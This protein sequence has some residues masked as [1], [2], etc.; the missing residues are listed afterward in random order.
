MSAIRFPDGAAAYQKDFFERLKTPLLRC[1]R[2][3]D[4]LNKYYTFIV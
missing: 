4:F 3:A 2:G 1:S